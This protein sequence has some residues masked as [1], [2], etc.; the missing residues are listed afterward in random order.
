MKRGNIMHKQTNPF[1][2]LLLCLFLGYLGA[3]RFYAGKKKSGLLYLFTLGVFGIGWIIDIV[4]IGVKCFRE[5][6][7]VTADNVNRELKV[8]KFT[9]AG[10]TYYTE[11]IQKLAT[12]NPE[13][14]SNAAQIASH[15]KMNRRIYRFNYVN[16]P[17][18]LIP[19]PTNPH[20]KNALQ[21]IIAGELV[22]YISR[23]DNLHVKQIMDK[24]DVKYISGFIGG[25]EYK[26]VDDNKQMH[27][28]EEHNHVT[29]NIGY[30]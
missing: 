17:V 7:S 2:E 12:K 8:E 14:Q 1:V 13:W 5:L 4:L 9:A 25:G 3:H 11:N 29:V 28:F 15:G 22:G 26:V 18:K 27:H 21:I 30:V 16:K 10:V 20:D 6:Q 24:H 19:E 23:E